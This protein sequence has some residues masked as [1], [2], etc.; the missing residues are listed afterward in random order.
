[1]GR[2]WSKMRSRIMRS[3]RT[4]PDPPIRV[5]AE[6][7]GAVSS[8]QSP[9]VVFCRMPGADESNSPCIRVIRVA[10]LY[11][12]VQT[13]GDARKQGQK[14]QTGHST[15]RE[16]VYQGLTAGRTAGRLR[17]RESRQRKSF[18]RSEWLGLHSPYRL[19]S[20]SQR[21]FTRR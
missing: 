21:L 13:A 1:M 6:A 18:H 14:H 10:V 5:T 11:G 9:G 2:G 20:Y 17:E 19:A 12:S 7:Y 3:T 16:N 8:K 4:L 15:K